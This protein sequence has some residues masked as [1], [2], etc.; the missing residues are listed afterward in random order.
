M[1]NSRISDIGTILCKSPNLGINCLHLGGA[2]MSTFGP[3]YDKTIDEP[4]LST[5]REAILQYVRAMT[6]SGAWLTLREISE[7]T[8]YPEASVSAQLRHL[9]KPQFGGWRVEKRR[10]VRYEVT[11]CEDGGITV[12]ENKAA[13]TWEYRILLPMPTGQQEFWGGEK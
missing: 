7:D 11:G 10:R 4:R 6:C 2:K 13:G 1:R 12:G 5:Q 8:G 3:A 9:R